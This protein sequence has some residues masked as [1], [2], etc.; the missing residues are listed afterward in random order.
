M[1]KPTS[2]LPAVWEL[3]QAFRDR[4]GTRAGRQRAMFADGHLLLV[5]HLPP[6]PDDDERVARFLWRKPD[7][8]WSSNDLGG[9]V[10]ALG[11]HLAQYAEVI[12]RCE[13]R[14]RDASAAE[15]YFQLLEVLAPIH[16]AARNLHNVLQD[17]RKHVPEDRELINMRDKAY[18][19]E[20]NAELLYSGAKNSL[21]FEVARRAEQ[22][23]K[24]AH[25]MSVAAHRLNI[26]A[27]F[28][29]PL[30]TLSSIFGM[31]LLDGWN[32]WT[33]PPMMF[34]IICVVGLLCGV[35]LKGWVTG[36]SEK[37]S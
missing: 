12:D 5:L 3:P 27:A 35:I 10:G 17:A 9:G 1:T 2:I 13:Q 29:F 31:T 4:L 22:Q 8:Q 36:G 19:L 16:R 37:T 6:S 14:E 33:T 26:L 24:A 25:N 34:L 20:R 15:D 30:A 21:D 18:D 28:F 32:G 11:K 23:A 7:G